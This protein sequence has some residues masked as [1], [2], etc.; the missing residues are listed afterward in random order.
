MVE[1]KEDAFR[2]AK[3][4]DPP[5]TVWRDGSRQNNGAV[6]AGGVWRSPVGR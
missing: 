3:G 2:R 4:W 5:D 1:K 6:G